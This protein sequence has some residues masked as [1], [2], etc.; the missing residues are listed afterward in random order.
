MKNLL[1]AAAFAVIG[2]AAHAN[3]I[4]FSG[5][6]SM[7]LQA[8]SMNGTTEISPIARFQGTASYTIETDFGLTM[9]VAFEFDTSLLEDTTPRFLP[10]HR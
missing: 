6:V 3:D 1:F 4:D 9:V 2:S 10:G 8:T 5:T 7:G